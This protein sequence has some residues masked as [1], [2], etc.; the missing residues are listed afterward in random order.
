L[1]LRR[2][3]GALALVVVFTTVVNLLGLTGS[4]F[5]L[6]VYDRVLPSRSV[7]TL[8][9]LLVLIVGLYAVL[10]LLDAFRLQ[11]GARIGAALQTELDPVLFRATLAPPQGAAGEAMTA[12]HDLEAV[13]KFLSSPLAFAIFDLP[14]APFYLG[15]IFLFHPYLG[16]LAVG[17]GLVLVALM[18]I[19]QLASRRRVEAATRTSIGAVRTSEFARSNADTIRSLAME[20]HATARWQDDRRAALAAEIGLSDLNGGFG[21]TVKSLRMLL[22]S[23]MLGLAAWLVM[24][25]EMTAGGMIASSILT[26]RALAPVEQLVG[27][28]AQVART[29]KGWASLTRLLT[30]IAQ[31][32]KRTILNPPEGQ[33]TVTD[34]TVVPPGGSRPTLAKVSFAVGPGQALG[35]IGESATGKSTLARALVGLWKPF[36]GEIRLDRA[37][38]DQYGSDLGRYIGYMPQDIVLFEGTVAENIARLDRNAKDADVIRAATLAGAH[39]LILGLPQGY[40]T[41]IGAGGARL[42]GGQKQR[43]GLARALYGDPVLVVLDEPNANLD[44]AG[45]EAFNE[46]VRQLKRD[47][48]SIIIVAHRPSALGECDLVLVLRDGQALAFGP[49]DDVLKAT[50]QNHAKLVPL[51]RTAE[52]N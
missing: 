34:L 16:W 33:L 43:V 11:V 48:K 10:A 3:S 23:G 5:M 37:R 32:G 28:W 26:S 42:S 13:R 27:G 7:E 19:N 8:V 17:G 1:I 2:H 45:S 52:V 12:L 49:R 31:E 9:I 50:V 21:S 46:A 22:Q 39:P 24:R 38:I 41:L 6:Q 15:L 14:F 20:L 44:A 30:S 29:R 36:A 51:H 47:G 25:G 18:L 35:V 4:L 40:D